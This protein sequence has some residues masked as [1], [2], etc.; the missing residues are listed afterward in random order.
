M[1]DLIKD[2]SL[3][4]IFLDAK[5]NWIRRVKAGEDFHSNKG[6]IRYDDL[7]GRP[8]GLRVKS[9]SGVMF[10]IHRPSQT[11]V[12]IAMGRNTQIVYPKDAATILIEAGIVSGTRVVESGT[13]SGALTGILSRAVGLSGHVYTY[14]IR[15]D[16][17]HGAKKNLERYDLMGNITMYNRDILEGIQEEDVDAVVL[18]LATPWEIVDEAHRVLKPSHV[19]ASYSPTI[20]QVMKTCAALRLEGKWGMIKTLE[21]LSREIMVRENKTRPTTWMVGHTGYMTFART[22]VSE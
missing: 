9:H 3:V 19:L 14:E 10:Q 20:E 1:Q 12:Q 15:E 5:R 8:Y 7:I 11:D 6:I 21:V 13:G 4:Y 22:M 16:M 17:Y 18:D 2:G